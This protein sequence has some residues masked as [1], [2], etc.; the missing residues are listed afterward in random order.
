M[1]GTA[2]ICDDDSVARHLA[3][4]VVESAGY[5]VAAEVD[6][7]TDAVRVAEMIK[8]EVVVIDV[9]LTGLSGLDAIPLLHG[10]SPDTA[11]VVFSSFD[12]VRQEAMDAGAVAVAD[13]AHPDG[14]REAL[15]TI[16]ASAPAAG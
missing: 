16:T 14:L 10:V 15:E 6:M 11:V 5:T 12:S 2:V 13:K 4:L 8:P 1:P 3:R 9:A 7:A